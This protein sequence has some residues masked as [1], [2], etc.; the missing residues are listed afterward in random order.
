[1]LVF[2]LHTGE[3][4]PLSVLS[5]F[6]MI[7]L[8][9]CLYLRPYSVQKDSVSSQAYSKSRQRKLST[10]F[11]NW[12]QQLYLYLSSNKCHYILVRCCIILGQ[13]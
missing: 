5:V 12:I 2:S 8:Y 13:A 11:R 4:L 3:S 9:S 1:M 7:D 10:M 6:C